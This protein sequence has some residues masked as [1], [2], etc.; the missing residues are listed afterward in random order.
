M[1]EP[2]KK[3]AY[4]SLQRQE[5]AQVTRRKML[6]AARRLFATH[7]YVATTLPAIAREAGVAA[8]TVTAVFG[9][10]LALLNALITWAV[11]GDEEPAP[12]AMR[13]WWQEMLSEREPIRQLTLYAAIAR[14][15]HERTTDLFEIVRGAATAEPEIAVLWRD[16]KESHL[17][18]DR[19]VAESLAQKEALGRGVTVEHATDLL[20]ALGSADLYR[21]LV[22]ERGWPP[23]EYEQWLAATWI[24]ALLGPRG[25]QRSA[26]YENAG[27]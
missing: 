7:G 17:Q 9:T 16:L 2:G 20:W 13:E 11:R 3:R 4:H 10:K 14:R 6:E 22:V 12:L 27:R 25:T 1:T 18:D 26:N 19:W 21:L 8:A 23:E 24:H 15:I 5:Q